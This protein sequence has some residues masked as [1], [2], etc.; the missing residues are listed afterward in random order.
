[1]FKYNNNKLIKIETGYQNVGLPTIDS[2][3]KHQTTNEFLTAMKQKTGV[4]HYEVLTKIC[5]LEK[6]LGGKSLRFLSFILVFITFYIHI[7]AKRISHSSKHQK[8]K[9]N[10]WK[11]NLKFF[12]IDSVLLKVEQLIIKMY[13]L[14]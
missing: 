14:A 13:L 8:Q 6:V 11:P 12:G 7:L 5:K 3:E 10:F 1:M 2:V 9:I 4:F